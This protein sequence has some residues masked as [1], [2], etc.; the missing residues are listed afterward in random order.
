[1]KNTKCFRSLWAVAMVN[2]FQ[3]PNRP[4]TTTEL[5]RRSWK[6]AFP[7]SGSPAHFQI[8]FS[9]RS[10]SVWTSAFP[11]LSSLYPHQPSLSCLSLFS[12][13]SSPQ[14]LSNLEPATVTTT[15][16]VR[17]VIGTRCPAA[18]QSGT[19]TSSRHNQHNQPTLHFPNFLTTCV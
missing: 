14:I 4:L 7:W 19:N 10:R 3:Y 11:P 5:G 8:S 13:R 9:I 15:E 1:M 16:L 17:P 18:G 12:Y 2:P 6:K